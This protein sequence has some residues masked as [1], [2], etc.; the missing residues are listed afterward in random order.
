MHAHTDKMQSCITIYNGQRIIAQFHYRRNERQLVVQQ[1]ALHNEQQAEDIVFEFLAEVDIS[2]PEINRITIPYS[3]AD[4][5][6][7]VRNG[8]TIAQDYHFNK[9]SKMDGE[10]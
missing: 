6:A 10:R 5:Q 2:Y 8:F 7:L 3:F 9:K 1:I 4:R